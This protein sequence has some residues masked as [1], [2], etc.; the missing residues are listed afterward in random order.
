MT[1]GRARYPDEVCLASRTACL[2]G[3]PA[4]GR[5]PQPP[6]AKASSRVLQRPPVP[7]AAVRDAPEGR[8]R[9]QLKGVCAPYQPRSSDP[10][11]PEKPPVNRLEHRCRHP[12][13][14]HPSP[15]HTHRWRWRD[16]A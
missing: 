3:T 8:V 1:V 12:K 13:R 10:P 4:F 5:D 2:L 7:L 6:K 15:A 11:G 16:D 14:V 9:S